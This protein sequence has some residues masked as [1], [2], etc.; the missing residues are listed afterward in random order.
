[1][2]GARERQGIH[3]NM[4]RKDFWKNSSLEELSDEEWESLCDGC[5]VCCLYKVED[6]KT[7]R[8]RETGVTCRYLDVNTCRCSIY[9]RRTVVNPHC[10]R[11][12]RNDLHIPKWLPHTCAYRTL[13]EGRA[14]QWWHPLL[15]GDPGTVHEAGISIRGRVISGAC[16]HPE[17]IA[18]GL[19]IQKEKDPV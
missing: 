13:A 17:E 3:D 10:I 15:S 6:S 11:F 5:A 16:V 1:L 8:I 18:W 14:L 12:D 2:R 19:N 4:I 7:G 9:A